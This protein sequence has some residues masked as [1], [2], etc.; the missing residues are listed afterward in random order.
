MAFES[1]PFGLYVL[2]PVTNAVWIFWENDDFRERPTLFFDEQ[3][4]PMGDVVDLT[5][6][7]EELYLLHE[8]GHLTTCR[9]GY[10]TRCE[11]PAM[12]TDLR[13]GNIRTPTMDGLAFQ[14]IQLTN[15]PDSSIFL[16]EPSVPSIFRFTLRLNFHNQY[17]AQEPLAEGEAT[18]FHVSSGHQIFLAIGNQVYVAPL[19]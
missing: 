11:D 1:T 15:P 9:F 7:R 17:R 6:N 5:L 12:I 3:V 2:D 18:A 14:E 8:D 13:Y 16:L 10:P 19:P 4:P